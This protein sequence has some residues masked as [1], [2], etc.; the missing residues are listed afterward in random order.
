MGELRG[1]E[2]SPPI[3]APSALLVMG[4]ATSKSSGGPSP[5]T[6]SAGWGTSDTVGFLRASQTRFLPPAPQLPIR[7]PKTAQVPAPTMAAAGFLCKQR[8]RGLSEGGTNHCVSFGLQGWQEVPQKSGGF[9]GCGGTE[10]G[11][12]GPH[13]GCVWDPP[14]MRGTGVGWWSP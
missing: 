12:Q 11:G 7:A 13:G 9:L 10:G 3:H 2:T 5:A 6:I 4:E 8:A 1:G 14:E